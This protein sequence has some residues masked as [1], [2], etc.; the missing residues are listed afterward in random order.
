MLQYLN[1]LTIAAN[2][3]IADTG[4]TAIFITDNAD[5]DNK[6]IA[7]KPLKINLPDGTTIW[8]T[9]VCNI[10]IPGLPQILTGNINLSLKIASLI[11]I[12]PLCKA[13]CKVVFDNEKGKVWYNGTVILA[14]AKDQATNIMDNQATKHIKQFLSENDCKLQ[15]VEPHNHRVNAAERAIQTFKCVYRSSSHYRC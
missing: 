5:V 3:A 2:K 10:K 6:R 4:S 8:S 7:T 1:A 12:R 9:H 14:G 13:G 11:G 15:P